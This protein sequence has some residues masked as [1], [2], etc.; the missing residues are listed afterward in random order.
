MLQTMAKKIE[1]NDNPSAL[2]ETL[3]SFRCEGIEFTDE[4]L[5]L[6]S[7]MELD[8]LSDEE[9]MARIDAF[10]REKR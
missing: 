2:E 7:Q 8:S 3:A 5:A 6:L 1:P 9:R 4:E 10:L